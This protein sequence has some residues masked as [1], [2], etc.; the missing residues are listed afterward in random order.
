MPKYKYNRRFAYI[1]QVVWQL[2]ILPYSYC[3]KSFYKIH[4]IEMIG[5]KNN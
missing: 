5:I 2:F 4:T 1:M 3:V